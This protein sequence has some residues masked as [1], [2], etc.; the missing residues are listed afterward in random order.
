M[1]FNKETGMYE[2]YIYKIYN[3]INDKIYIGQTTVTIVDRWHGHM[4]AALNEDRYQSILYN[5][6]R[7]YGRDK[8]HICVI[9]KIECLSKDLLIDELNKLE[10]LRIKQYGSLYTHNGYNFEV[11][12][13]NKKVPGRIVHQ[14]DINLNYVATYIFCEE[15]GRVNGLDGCTVY[16]CCKH[17]YYTAGGY[18]WVFDG[19]TPIKP[20]YLSRKERSE[21]SRIAYTKR[22][23][24]DKPTSYRIKKSNTLSDEEKRSNR[25][26]RLNW[27]GKKICVYNAFGEMIDMYDDPIDAIE[28]MPITAQELRKNLS[29]EYLKYH[30]VVI[31]YENEPFD[32]YPISRNLQPITVYDMRG[33]IV[34]F[35]DSI[36]AAE[37]FVGCT[38]GELLKTI[39]RG[40]SYKNYMFSFYGQPLVRKVYQWNKHIEMCN[41]DFVMLKSFDTIQ[42]INEYFGIVDCHHSLN[43]A[44]KNKTQYRGFYW[45]YKDEFAVNV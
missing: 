6:M 15:A 7:K 40:G 3:D 2:G 17:Y 1:S 43:K 33:D 37:R 23:P 5:A 18:I 42:Q 31:R 11:G 41:Q 12:G 19:E 25:L 36:I 27:N 35:F 20:Q 28:N 16:G 39:K 4:S 24:V 10:T 26:K 14:Y 22:K 30:N 45:K 44:I 34:E 8:F 9:D 38:R 29:G 32:K 21:K 13:N